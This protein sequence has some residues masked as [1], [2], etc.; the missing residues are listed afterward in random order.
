MAERRLIDDCFL[1]DRNRLRHA[2][3][4][5]I[6]RQR[7]GPVA[8]TETVPLA[9]AAGR[10]LAETILSSATVP[11]AD[12]AA[13]DG[14]AF[15]HGDYE[16]T[17]GW[18]PVSARIA[19]GH[20]SGE[21]LAPLSAA[22]IF[23][24]ALIPAGADTVAMQEDC[25]PHEQEGQRFVAVPPGL[26]PGANRR[27]AGEDLEPGDVIASAGERLRPQELGAIA[28]TGR[29]EVDVFRPLRVAL[30]STGDEVVRPGTP[31]GPDQVYDSNH[32]LL[33]GLLAT[34]G[35]EVT[36]LGIL[37]DRE[38]AVRQAL[39]EAAADHEAVITT[40]GA[41]RGEEDHVVT[42]L[43]TLGSR[44]IWQLAVKPGRPMTFGQIGDC[45]VLGLPGNPVAVFVCFLLYVRPTLLRLGGASWREP[46]RFLVEAD[47]EMGRKKPDRR[48]FLRGIL[49]EADGGRTV[50]RKFLR[51]G[52][53][54]I[55][56]LREADGL[57]ELEETVTSV[58]R[59]ALVRFIPFACL[60]LSS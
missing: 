56:S 2:D 49:A 16:A 21:A 36:D 9:A 34:I 29:T 22:R 37:P 31:K 55:T 44:H 42:G 51:D 26:K 57:I 30:A 18:F 32:Y 52:S 53:G 54:L 10:I 47:F 39:Q 41:S 20:P 24:G 11:A 28:S 19:A 13:V 4:L 6:L 17:G 8:G 33:R 1:H 43:D 3:A 15:A 7:V 40:G 12:N 48:E 35:A 59:G 45:A 50:V 60:G 23:T 27:R 38:A 14:Y 25:E 46:P 5:A 58:E